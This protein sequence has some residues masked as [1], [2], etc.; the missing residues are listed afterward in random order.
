MGRQLQSICQSGQYYAIKLITVSD[1]MLQ[2]ML[3]WATPLEWTACIHLANATVNAPCDQ[4]I[5]T[6]ALA[7]L[8]LSLCVMSWHVI[9]AAK[10]HEKKDSHYRTLEDKQP[11]TTTDKNVKV[12]NAYKWQRQLKVG[13]AQPG[14]L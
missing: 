1:A 5:A 4:E 3:T 12:D 11:G 13:R 2:N 9:D 6:T 7:F 14:Y 10:P 8:I